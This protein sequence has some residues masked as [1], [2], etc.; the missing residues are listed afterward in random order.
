MLENKNNEHLS[1]KE[2]GQHTTMINYNDY[3]IKIFDSFI[4]R[5]G[6]HKVKDDTIGVG[7]SAHRNS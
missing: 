2:Y 6:E 3:I 1:G 5:L 4:K 7:E